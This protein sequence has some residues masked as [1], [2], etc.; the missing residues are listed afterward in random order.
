[1]SAAQ[2][3]ASQGNAAHRA[4]Q[5]FGFWEVAPGQQSRGSSLD[6]RRALSSSSAGGSADGSSAPPEPV[7]PPAQTSNL[8]A[9]DNSRSASHGSLAESDG[10]AAAGQAYAEKDAEGPAAEGVH[11]ESSSDQLVSQS[12]GAGGAA[13]QQQQPQQKRSWWFGGGN[14]KGAAA[15]KRRERHLLAAR[16]LLPAPFS[17]TRAKDD[18]L[19]LAVTVCAHSMPS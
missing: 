13:G 10:A 5:E 14:N 11:R 6:G 3:H 16:P 2:H 4:E 8:A 12:G 15:E 17:Q 7:L 19:R 9:G 1:V 18:N